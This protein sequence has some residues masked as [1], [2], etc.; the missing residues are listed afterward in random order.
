MNEP[1]KSTP[2]GLQ[3]VDQFT[4]LLDTKYRIPGTNIRFGG[5]FILGLIPGLGDAASLGLSGTLIA[6]MAKKGASPKLV[7]R[8]LI[9]VLVDTVVG[10]IPVLGNIFDLFFKANTRNLKLMRE[11]YDEDKHQG[12]AM[13]LIIGIFVFMLLM[14]ALAAI[15]IYALVSWGISWSGA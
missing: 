10:S 6:T 15:G 13:P 11:Y 8:M 3:W 1:S 14:L 2:R 7:A 4:D 12:S 5:D 9:N